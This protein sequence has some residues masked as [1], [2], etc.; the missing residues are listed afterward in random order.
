V[1]VLETVLMVLLG[2]GAG[3]AAA[4]LAVA[5]AL[6]SGQARLPLAWI[7]AA[8]G[9]TLVAAVTAAAFA[10]TRAVIPPRPQAE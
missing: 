9:L 3:V 1:L 6:A 4:L 8:G 10:T 2:L 7:T 5:P